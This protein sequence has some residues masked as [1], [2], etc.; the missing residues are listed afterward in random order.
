MSLAFRA[1][2][3]LN[4]LYTT[5]I[6]HSGTE[7][8]S[9]TELDLNPIEIFRFVNMLK[10]KKIISLSVRSSNTRAMNDRMDPKMMA[11]KDTGE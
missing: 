4:L 11:S 2:F 3:D 7:I 10:L 5:N 6:G 8:P 9:R 1:L